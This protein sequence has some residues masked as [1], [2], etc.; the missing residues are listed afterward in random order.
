MEELL[1]QIVQRLE[2][3]EQGQQTLR[4][5]VGGLKAGQ[6]ELREEFSGLKAGQQRLEEG[7]SRLRRDFIGLRQDQQELRK[8][9]DGLQQ[10]QQALREDV[11]SIRGQLNENTALIRSLMH[12][13]ETV[14]AKV[15]GL[16]V[17]TLTKDVFEQLAT[18][19]DIKRLDTKFE[20][21][22]SRLFN[23]EVEIHQLKAVK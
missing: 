18:K 2:R 15:D 22:N 4:E 7:Q 10:G 6:Q 13:V 14:N 9:F 21:V 5:D 20:V 12:N 19:E 3:M 23:Q 8:E 16:T 11:G 17:S 1:K